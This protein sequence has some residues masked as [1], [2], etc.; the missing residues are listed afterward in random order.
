MEKSVLGKG[1]SALIPE[2]HSEKERIQTVDIHKVFASKYQ[3]R[4]YFSETKIAELAN[5]IKEKGMIQPI[6]V[7]QAMDGFEIIAGER[8]FRA[9]K[10][11]G[12]TTI[13]VIVKNVSNEDVLEIS[14]I[15]NIQREEL[16]RMEEA[17]AY[18]RLADEFRMT[19]DEISKK[20]SKDRASIT[21]TLRLLELP[22]KIQVFL[23]E[24]TIT[25]GH[26]KSLLSVD[27]EKEQ[28]KLCARII[29]KGLSVRQTEQWVRSQMDPVKKTRK[30]QKDIFIQDWEDKLQHYFGTR[31]R[32]EQGI[33][34][35][36]LIIEYFSKDDLNRVLG[37][38]NPQRP[39]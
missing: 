10:L 32:I 13:P 9:S 38:I 28:A 22:E 33:K 20:V 35:G 11:L 14:L 36:K 8:R 26:A 4:Q 3:P 5:S 24:N 34:R 12:Y 18:K 6:V 2:G 39:S 16:N 15:E 25:M 17:R 31:V 30:S 19:H 1:L 29:K 23:E 21:N 7:R 37:L 27:N